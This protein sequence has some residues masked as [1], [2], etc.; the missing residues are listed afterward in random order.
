MFISNREKRLVLTTGNKS[1]LAVGYC[2]LYGDMAGGLAVLADLPKTMV[3]E[4][5]SYLNRQAGRYI[6][7]HITLTKPPS[8]VLRPHKK[9]EDSL[10]PYVEL[11]PILNLYVEQ[12]M[13]TEKIIEQGHDAETVRRVAALVDRSEYKRRQAAPGLRVTTRAF[14]LGRRMPIARGYD[15][16]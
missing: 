3:Y 14:G 1:E 12:N 16:R 5:A 10:Q 13:A 8:A 9:D 15:Y 4:M 11:D 2:T 7:P 6:I